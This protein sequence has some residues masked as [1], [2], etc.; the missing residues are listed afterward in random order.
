MLFELLSIKKIVSFNMFIINFLFIKMKPL[1]HLVHVLNKI[2]DQYINMII[3]LMK[4]IFA[5]T[6]LRKRFFVQSHTK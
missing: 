2:F 1:F 4:N 6:T 5:K 3:P